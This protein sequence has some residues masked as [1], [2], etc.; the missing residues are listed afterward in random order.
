MGYRYSQ[1][2]S[3]E[4]VDLRLIDDWTS[5]DYD[6]FSWKNAV[7]DHRP[8]QGVYSAEN[9]SYAKDLGYK[10]IFW[11]L[12]YAD[13]DNQNQ[14]EEAA[15]ISKLLSRTHNGAVI[16]LH[17]TSRTNAKI[18][19]RLLTQWEEQGYRFGTLDAL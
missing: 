3:G 17:S 5:P 19:D 11:S 8:P 9:L 12:A 10:T 15:A 16:L 18:L 14:P 2:R 1:I 7:I 6:D 13:W 4:Y